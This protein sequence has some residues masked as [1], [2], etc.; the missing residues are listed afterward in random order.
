MTRR[1]RKNIEDTILRDQK[2]LGGLWKKLTDFYRL[3]CG[4]A[5]VQIL[6]DLDPRNGYCPRSRKF[7][8]FL[9]Q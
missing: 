4:D 6:L 7:E 8:E 2:L 5:T 1:T 9:K 3:R